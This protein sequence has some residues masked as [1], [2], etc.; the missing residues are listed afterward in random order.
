MDNQGMNEKA[1]EVAENMKILD[2]QLTAVANGDLVT[3]TPVK[4]PF[5]LRLGTWFE[6]NPMYVEL[7]HIAQKVVMVVLTVGVLM[8]MLHVGN[9]I[10]TMRDELKKARAT[11]ETMKT[12]IDNLTAE[13]HKGIKIRLW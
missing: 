6:Q 5:K 12:T 11:I 4:T 7:F 9:E 2:A 10:V 3:G 13:I 1:R 8:S